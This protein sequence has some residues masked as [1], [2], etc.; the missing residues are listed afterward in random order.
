MLGCVPLQVLSPATPEAD[1]IGGVSIL[2][3]A[4]CA[5]IFLLVQGALLYFVFRFRQREGER[6][7]AEPPQ[8]YGSKPIEVAWTVAPLL[9][10]FVI[11][12]VVVRVTGQIRAMPR[13]DPVHVTVDGYRW[14]WRYA[15]QGDAPDAA[16]TVTANE[17]HVPTGTPIALRLVSA[18]VIHSFWVPRLNGKTDVIPGHPN[19][20]SFVVREPGV[21][22]G[23]C[24]EFCGLQHANMMVRVVADP[25][26]VYDRWLAHQA[27]P[28]V[29]DPSAHDGRAAFFDLACQSCHTIRGTEANGENGPDLTHLMTRDTLGSGMVPNDR[30]HLAS[31]IRDPQA[32]KPGCLMPDMRLTDAQV[33]EITDYLMSLR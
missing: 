10:V 30:A 20:T 1:A 15:Y 31:W 29:D 11:F 21:Y 9:I 19:E 18:D 24:G 27:E 4:I 23:Q 26:D 16:P 14:W 28:A 2:V 5:V 25:P 33:E 7:L 17:L 12:L 32:V 6:R 13:E 3:L 8:L 22:R